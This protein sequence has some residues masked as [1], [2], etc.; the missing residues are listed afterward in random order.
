MELAVAG[1]SKTLAFC[2]CNCLDYAKC[3]IL[4]LK[5]QSGRSKAWAEFVKFKVFGSHGSYPKCK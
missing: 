2:F 4:F 3:F 1:S 5:I